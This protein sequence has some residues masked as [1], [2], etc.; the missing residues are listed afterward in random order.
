[1]IPG[2]VH[3]L[4]WAFAWRDAGI[5]LGLLHGVKLGQ[6]ATNV[7]DRRGPLVQHEELRSWKPE[8]RRYAAYDRPNRA[9]SAP[10]HVRYDGRTSRTRK[11]IRGATQRRCWSEDVGKVNHGWHPEAPD[12]QLQARQPTST[13]PMT[14]LLLSW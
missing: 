12:P 6:D 9:S 11:C 3:P 4:I 13:P 8:L 7:T 2:R 1:M 10:P 5:D 14:A